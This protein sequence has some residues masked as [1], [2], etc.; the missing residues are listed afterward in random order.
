MRPPSP[1]S[2]LPAGRLVVALLALLAPTALAFADG[3]YF[4]GA[5]DVALV[6]A[7]VVLL[8]TALVVPRPRLSTPGLLAVGGLAALTAW[9]AISTAWAPSS[10]PAWATAERDALYLAALAAAGLLLAEPRV[11]ARVV[12][13]VLVAGAVVVVG[14]GLLGRLLPDVLHV[15]PSASAG[16]RLDQPLTYWNAMGALAAV[17][18]VLAARLAGDHTRAPALRC[19]AAAAAVPLFAG[20]YL[21]FSRGAIAACAAGLVVLLAVAPSFTQLRAVAIAA[22]AG[23]VGAALTAASPYVR[24]L[25][26]SHPSLQGAAVLV[27]LLGVMV[28]AVLTQAW[29]VR[30]EHDRSARL[31]RLPLPSRHGWVAA[32][33]VAA[34]LVVPVAIAAGSDTPSSVDPRFGSSTSRLASAD[35]PRYAYWRVAVGSFADHPVQ[36]VGAGGFAVEWLRERKEASPARDAHSL[37]I[38]TLAELGL[39]GAAA[40]A[41]LAAGVIL[42]TRRVLAADPALAAGPAAALVAYAFHASIDW[43]WEMPALSLVA[44][45]LAG[46]MIARSSVSTETAPSTTSDGSAAKRNRVE[47]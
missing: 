27:G 31:G 4:E 22:E 8:L 23:I 24:T 13:P 11:L 37:P 30:V 3:G 17:G 9:T 29:A 14:Y 42:A 7:G 33:L 45:L 18:A 26:G 47:P 20:L 36:G 2:R 21:T 19:A 15:I 39:I 41:L 32:A 43:D 10:D 44:V 1:S 25:H 35:S 12:E 38:E 16:G 40:L 28:V 34:M 5:R 6:G 46:L